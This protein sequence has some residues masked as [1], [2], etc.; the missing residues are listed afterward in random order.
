[1]NLQE[2]LEKHYIKDLE[3]IVEFEDEDEECSFSD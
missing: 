3:N 2:Y 1:M